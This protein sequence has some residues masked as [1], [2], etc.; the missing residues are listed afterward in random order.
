MERKFVNTNERLKDLIAHFVLRFNY[1]GYLFT[2]IRRKPLPGFKSIMG[3]GPESD[4][5]ISLF[6]NPDMVDKTDDKTLEQVLEHEGMHLLNDHISRSLRIL[7]AHMHPLEAQSKMDIFNHAADCAVNSQA[8]LPEILQIAGKPWNLC[9]PKNY[10]LEN[11]KVTEWY[12]TQLLKSAKQIPIF[13]GGSGG[14]GKKKC[15]NCGGSGQDPNQ[16]QGQQDQGSGGEGQPQTGEESNQGSGGE[17]QGQ[18]CPVCGGKGNVGGE[19]G[20]GMDS[21]SSWKPPSDVADVDSLARKVETHISGIVRESVKSFNKTRGTIP[22]HLEQLIANILAPPQIPYY[23]LIAKYVRGTRFSKFK[24]SFTTIN[25]KRTYLFAFGVGG[26]PDISPFP[27]RK[28]D[29]SFKIGILVDTSGSQGEDDI[30][31]ALRGTKHIIESDRHT[32]TIVIE[33]DTKI[34]KEYEVKRVSDIQ[35]DVKGRGGTILL[36]A[37]ERFKELAVDVCLIFTDGM[38]D[39]INK[40]QRRNLPKKIIWV[41]GEKSGRTN[42]IDK[43][44]PIVK[45]PGL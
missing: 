32:K 31:E 21:H 38:C 3:V 33:N 13:S 16:D 28:R 27:G 7:S 19:S 37:L 17:G 43:T 34:Q 6:Y 24:R 25:R 4:G 10:G 36:P 30:C 12:Y 23:Q 5:T 26:L 42:L 22:G 35:P 18:Q 29:F 11:G 15:P 40:I 1:W 20:G 2:R 9:H 8:K 45:V 41:I 14:E 44:G 39:N